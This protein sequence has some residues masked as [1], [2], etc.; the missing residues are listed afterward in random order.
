V[1]IISKMKEAA[2]F[3]LVLQEV[4]SKMQ[5]GNWKDAYSLNREEVTY[6]G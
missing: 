5:A 1:V 3:Q 4:A 6:S 2:T